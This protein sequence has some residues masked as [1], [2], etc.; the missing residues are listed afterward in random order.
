MCYYDT[1]QADTPFDTLKVVS[2]SHNHLT[3]K[4]GVTMTPL[5][6]QCILSILLVI[7]KRS[8]QVEARSVKV[9]AL[10]LNVSTHVEIC[11]GRF[12]THAERGHVLEYF[13]TCRKDKMYSGMFLVHVGNMV[14]MP[15]S[16]ACFQYI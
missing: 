10:C 1:D 7:R 8:H 15:P 4:I 12:P 11:A 6:L 14:P 2:F 13:F 9:V 3:P 16:I 5:F